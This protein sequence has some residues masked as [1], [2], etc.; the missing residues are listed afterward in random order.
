MLQSVVR[1]ERQREKEYL[2]PLDPNMSHCL[3]GSRRFDGR[4]FLRY[5]NLAQHG[6]LS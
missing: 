5:T 2:P 6:W 3:C 4:L 1:T